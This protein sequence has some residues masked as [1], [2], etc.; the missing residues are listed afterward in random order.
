MAREM[1]AIVEDDV[2]RAHLSDN[3]AQK[4][5]I[6]L[7][8]DTHLIWR[9]AAIGARRVDVD[10]EYGCRVSQVATPQF[11][12]ATL[13]DADFEHLDV[14]PTIPAQ[15]TFIYWQV[16]RPLVHAATRRREEEFADRA[17]SAQL[18]A[19]SLD[20]GR[21]AVLQGQTSRQPQEPART[22]TNP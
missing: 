3:A 20:I 10:P 13:G 18:S 7:R 17:V 15:V 14:G 19:G 6:S 21:E 2:R 5:W 12:R 1:R 22:P 9:V 4:C 16:V 11:Q 8:P